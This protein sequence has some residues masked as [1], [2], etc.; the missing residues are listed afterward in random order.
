MIPQF[1]YCVSPRSV[2]DVGALVHAAVGA[3]Y[4]HLDLT[5]FPGAA[6]MVAQGLGGAEVFL[7]VPVNGAE[8]ASQL[9][10]MGAELGVGLLDLCV[11][12]VGGLTDPAAMAQAWLR[13]LEA[14]GAGG[15]RTAGVRNASAEQ[16][17]QL[18]ALGPV[19][20]VNQV[21]LNPWTPQPEL[22]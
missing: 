9:A 16:I 7:T 5:A 17:R 8:P 15:A 10:K 20:A 21:V 1:V 6:P 22:R 14:V 13:V 12:D 18:A 2:E 4:R 11:P 3:G 19:P